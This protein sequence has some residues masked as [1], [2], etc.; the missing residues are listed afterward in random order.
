MI[1]TLSTFFD[2]L[3]QIIH[4]DQLQKKDPD[5]RNKPNRKLGL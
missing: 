5:Q 1:E 3:D 2:V 4:A